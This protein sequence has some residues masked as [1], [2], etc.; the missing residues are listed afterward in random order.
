MRSEQ[1]H[2]LFLIL[3]FAVLFA[4][5]T[6][7][8]TRTARVGGGETESE[9]AELLAA[10]TVQYTAHIRKAVMT[11][12]IGN[13]VPLEELNFLPPSD[14]NFVPD[15]R[16]IFHPEGG[17]VPYAKPDPA[18][19]IPGQEG[20]WKFYGDLE[21]ADFGLTTGTVQ[22]VDVVAVLRNLNMPFCTGLDERIGMNSIPIINTALNFGAAPGGVRT[23]N[24]ANVPSALQHSAT[25]DLSGQ[26]YAV[27]NPTSS[28]AT[29]ACFQNGAGG[30]YI[31]YDILSMR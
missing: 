23:Y 24:P 11:M 16:L 18:I 28:N 2:V 20:T 25:L 17:G 1:G 5:L 22:G 7:A 3:I 21:V 26:T 4:A 27:T 13:D 9:K 30:E 19:F 14:P 6:Y 8:V 10:Q 31:F 12:T 29:P 15:A